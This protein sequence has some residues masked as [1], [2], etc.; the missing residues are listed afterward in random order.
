MTH[1]KQSL[2]SQFVKSSPAEKETKD[3]TMHAEMLWAAFL[4]EHN[5]SRICSHEVIKLLKCISSEYT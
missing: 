2:M 4:A 5:I 3:K 1:S